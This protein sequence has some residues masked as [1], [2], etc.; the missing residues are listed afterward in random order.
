MTMLGH[1]VRN[2]WRGLAADRTIWAVTALLAAVILYGAYNGVRWGSLQTERRDNLT[3]EQ[4][5]QLADTRAELFEISAGGEPRRRFYDPRNPAQ[6]GQTFAAAYAILPPA[7]LAPLSVGQSD[8][9]PGYYKVTLDSREALFAG[10][11]L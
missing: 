5:Q 10:D 9:L 8:L 7:P 4:Q 1:I 3:E 6:V 11:E 2:D